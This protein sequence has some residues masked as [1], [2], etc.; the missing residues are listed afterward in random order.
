MKKL[1]ATFHGELC[2][3]GLNE[4]PISWQ[5]DGLI[6]GLER[7]SAE[8]QAALDAVVAAHEP[9]QPVALP[10]IEQIKAL[11]ASLENDIAKATRQMLIAAKLREAKDE[12]QSHD[13]LLKTDGVYRR[14][15]Y[16][17]A[18]IVPLREQMRGKGKT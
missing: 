5:E 3:A 17:E 14:M 16:V 9:D 10:V 7:L 1:G 13:D 18:L 4:L 11:E 12:G 2:S 8:Q 6:N 15:V